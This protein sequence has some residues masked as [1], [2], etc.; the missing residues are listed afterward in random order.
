MA[1]R[2]LFFQAFDIQKSGRYNLSVS[3]YPVD[4]RLDTGYLTYTSPH[5]GAHRRI[6][7]GQLIHKTAYDHY[8]LE[9]RYFEKRLPKSWLNERRLD[10]SKIEWD[11]T[12]KVQYN[13]GLLLRAVKQTDRTGSNSLNST[14]FISYLRALLEI[15]H[16]SEFSQSHRQQTV[17]R[18]ISIWYY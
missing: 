16:S 3:I 9:Y 11:L 15:S 6:V 7:E 12:D 18:L 5:L 1:V 17:Y 4:V 14:L 13:L 8:K 2:V 10:D